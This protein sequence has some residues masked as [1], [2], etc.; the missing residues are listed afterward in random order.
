MNIDDLLFI[1]SINP[2][3]RF[4]KLIEDENNES[5]DISNQ[6]LL[7]LYIIDE[8]LKEKTSIEYFYYIKH[9]LS[10]YWLLN[11]TVF[12][13]LTKLEF[14]RAI[15]ILDFSKLIY[16]FTCA[17]KFKEV[18][19]SINQLRINSWGREYIS[20]TN[21]IFNYS[22]QY[23]K[24]LEFFKEYFN[25]H[26]NQYIELTYLLL[27]EKTDKTVSRIKEINNNI[28]IQILS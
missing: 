12:K 3:K 27:E 14:D 24:I 9:D 6:I 21:L 23:K 18:D 19:D 11:K 20:N 22:N 16:R 13:E 7:S 25:V 5:L 2:L 4:E 17:R 26:K 8:I 15:F 1:N 28:K 10:I